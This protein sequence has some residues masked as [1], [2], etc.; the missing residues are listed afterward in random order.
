MLSGRASLEKK[1][2][3]KKDD[4]EMVN[5]NFLWGLLEAWTAK[6]WIKV[7][8]YLAN[9][10][11]AQI[12]EHSNNAYLIEQNGWLLH[13]TQISS[14]SKSVTMPWPPGRRSLDIDSYVPQV[15][16]RQKK[17]YDTG[18]GLKLQKLQDMEEYVGCSAEKR[19]REMWQLLSSIWRVVAWQTKLV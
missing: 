14:S 1:A 7:L 4:R 18:N 11:L 10:F 15:P 9:N 12:L 13:Q 3:E 17:L 8:A 19:L 5:I 2:L 16:Y 6:S